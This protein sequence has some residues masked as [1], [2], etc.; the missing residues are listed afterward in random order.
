MSTSG[1]TVTGRVASRDQPG[2]AHRAHDKLY[3]MQKG[4]KLELMGQAVAALIREQIL[5]GEVK[6]GDALR[7]AP[8]AEKLDVSITPVR[9]ALLQLARDGWVVHQPNRGFRVVPIRRDS[10][11]DTYFMWA[12]A[13]GELAARA[14]TR[15]N[16]ESIFVLR[17]LDAELHKLED[18]HSKHALDLNAELHTAIHTMA[19][20]PK[21]LWFAEAARRLVPLQFDSSFHSVP[22]WA[23]INRFGHSAVIDRIESGDASGARTL[24]FDHFQSTCNLLVTWLDGLDFWELESSPASPPANEVG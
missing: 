5:S 14:A 2:G 23:E 15:S 21:L 11:I 24:M 19:D 17:K 9:E 1:L 8:L 7:L 6:H 13:E 18:H 3:F 20:A 4:L 10:V 12:T 22:G 16:S